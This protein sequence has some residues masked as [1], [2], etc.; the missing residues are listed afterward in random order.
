MDFINEPLSLLPLMA[1][2]LALYSVG[3]V[4]YLN[5]RRRKHGR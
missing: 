5:H 4:L 3:M 1:L 2:L